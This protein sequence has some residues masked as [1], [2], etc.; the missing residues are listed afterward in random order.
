MVLDWKIWNKKNIYTKDK[1]LKY[2]CHVKNV[3]NIFFI[4]NINIIYCFLQL[5][6][7]PCQK[8]KNKYIIYIC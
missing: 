6:V 2:K 1:I 7:F 5:N 8:N 3:D 4:Y